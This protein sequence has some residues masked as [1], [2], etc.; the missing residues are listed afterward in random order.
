M[1]QEFIN[2]TASNLFDYDSKGRIEKVRYQPRNA[3]SF[4]R[5]AVSYTT[6]EIRLIGDH[7]TSI[8]NS[9]DTIHLYLDAGGR[10]IKR[11][12]DLFFEYT[13]DPTYSPRSYTHDTTLYLY[14]AA[15]FLSKETRMFQDS[16]WLWVGVE[17]MQNN[18][19]TETVNHTVQNG[20]L[21]STFGERIGT[22]YGYTPSTGNVVTTETKRET[23]TSFEYT[24]AYPNKTDFTN[25]LVLNE[26]YLLDVFP[27]NEKYKN[28][29][30]KVTISQVQKDPNGT[31]VATN[32]FLYTYEF[33]YNADGY[34]ASRVNTQQAGTKVSFF[35]TAQ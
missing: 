12:Q 21:V 8:S 30:E 28:L 20:N 34:V 29:P 13:G 5:Y 25:A 15:G 11:I 35:Y 6:N 27:T 18:R 22:G 4:V 31:V 14:D 24:K 17:T 3:P 9:I 32:N 19:S 16:S 23:T 7:N 26:I 1:R 33:T 10:L 2:D